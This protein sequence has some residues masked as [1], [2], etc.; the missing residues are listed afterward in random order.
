[1]CDRHNAVTRSPLSLRRKAERRVGDGFNF[2]VPKCVS[3]LYGLTRDK[4]LLDAF[5]QSVAGDS[6]ESASLGILYGEAVILF[7]SMSWTVEPR[8]GT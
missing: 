5:Q 7:G 8:C 4:R 1:M 6:V 2:H 3:L